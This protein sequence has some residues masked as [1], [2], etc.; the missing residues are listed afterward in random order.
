MVGTLMKTILRVGG[1]GFVGSVLRCG[2]TS[3]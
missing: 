1:G 3:G 2:A